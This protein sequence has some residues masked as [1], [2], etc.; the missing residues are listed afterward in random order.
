MLYRVREKRKELGMSQEELSEKAGVSRVIISKLEND[1][2]VV[3]TT[4][5]LLSIADAMNCRVSDI[6]LG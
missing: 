1:E 6:F 2:K 4:S 5:T 3:T